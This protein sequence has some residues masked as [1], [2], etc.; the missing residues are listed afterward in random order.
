MEG[1]KQEREVRG[2]REKSEAGE[3]GGDSGTGFWRSAGDPHAQKWK[4]ASHLTA[5]NWLGE[6]APDESCIVSLLS[7][8][9]SQGKAREKTLGRHCL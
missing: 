5:G 8:K 7:Y 2:R 3:I 1:S 9:Q 6:G 4:L